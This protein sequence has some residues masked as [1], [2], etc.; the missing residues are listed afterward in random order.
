MIEKAAPVSSPDLGSE[1]QHELPKRDTSSTNGEVYFTQSLLR[2]M[3]ETLTGQRVNTLNNNEIGGQTSFDD[4]YDRMK[5][6][7][8]LRMATLNKD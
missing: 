4:T 2:V 1:H 3:Q 8:V 5:A 7:S 6:D